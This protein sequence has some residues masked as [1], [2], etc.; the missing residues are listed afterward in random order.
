MGTRSTIE[1]IET[2]DGKE[3]PIAKVY[4]Q[5]D[6]YL[7]GV[8]KELCKWL[9]R[10]IMIDGIGL[11]QHTPEYANGLGCL[12]AQYVHDF[13]NGVGDL[14][15]DTLYGDE[16][17]DY[18]YKVIYELKKGMPPEGIPVNDC[19]TICVSNWDEKPFFEGKTIELLRYME[20]NN[21]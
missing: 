18:N 12:A 19:V 5:Y 16:Y 7:A 6:G 9:I 3:I 4:Q 10:K 8:G 11:D 21:E 15:L 13:K 14:Y 17:I 1:F 20:S 2:Y